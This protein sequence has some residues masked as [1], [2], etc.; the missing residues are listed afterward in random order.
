MTFPSNHPRGKGFSILH[1]DNGRF[2]DPRVRGRVAQ[3][4]VIWQEQL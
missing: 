3:E 4:I 1:I 2:K